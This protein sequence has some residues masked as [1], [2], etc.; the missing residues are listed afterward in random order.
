MIMI[1]SRF[2]FDYQLLQPINGLVYGYFVGMV[3]AYVVER[4]ENFTTNNLDEFQ[5]WLNWSHLTY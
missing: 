5:R 2:F 3:H 1:E 4:V